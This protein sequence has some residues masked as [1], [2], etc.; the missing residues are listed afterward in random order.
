MNTLFAKFAQSFTI[1]FLL[2]V[3]AKAQTLIGATCDIEVQSQRVGENSIEYIKA[4]SGTPVVL[5]HGLYAQKEQWSEVACELSSAGFMVIAPDL[6]GYGK[7]IHFP[8]EDYRLERQ[9]ELLH[10]FAD[11]LALRKIHIAGSSMGGAIASMYVNKYPGQVHSLAFFGSPLGIGPWGVKVKAA[12]SQG[13]NPFIPITIDQFNSEMELLFYKPP[14]VPKI[15]KDQL[16]ADYRKSNRHYQQVWNIVNLYMNQI[17]RS[18]P[19]HIPTL[20]LW[21]KQDEIFPVAGLVAL[22]AKYPGNE[23]YILSDAGHLLMLEKP[24]EASFQYIQFLKQR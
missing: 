6:P 12:L 22:Q 11:L 21:G 24:K 5:L 2:L 15:I 1:I 18:S 14:E 8:V 16:L 9:V 17:A 19:V 23:H 3:T 10:R 4:G 7:S 13:V 20:I